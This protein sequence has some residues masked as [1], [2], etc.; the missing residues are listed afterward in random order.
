[1]SQ[2]DPRPW[3]TLYRPGLDESTVTRRSTLVD[4][5][6]DR[7][8]S[9]P[10]RVAIAYFDAMLSARD[11]DSMSDALAA[12]LQDRGVGSGDRVGIHL[13][14]IPQYALAM[15]ALW[16][17][18]AAAVVL[19]PM[20]FG[21]ELRLPVEDSGAVGI[22]A[23]DRDVPAIRD[24]VSGTAVAWVLSTSERDL[25]TRND[26]R[27]FGDDHSVAPSSDGD[28][29]VLMGEYQGRT[30]QRAEVTPDDLAL[31]T[32]TSGT[33]GPPKGAMNSHANVIAVARSFA[34][35]VG[36]VPGDVVLAIA[37]LFHITGAVINATLGLIE[38][39]TLVFAGRFR[40]EVV[41]DA[42][43]EHGVTFTI[44]SITAYNALMRLDE[45]RPEH[46]A[47]VKALY[48]GGA[49]IPPSTV[50]R[51]AERFGHY[52]HNGYGMTETTSG[53]IA[54]PP[55]QRAPVDTASGTL[56]IGVPLPGVEAAVVGVDDQPVGAGEQGEL[57]LS[58]PQI[59]SGYWRNEAATA[60]TMPGGR[61]HTGDVAVMDADG[62]VYLVDR[63]KDQ[64]NTSGYK[65]WPRE[66]EDALYEHDA[67]FE[68][69]VVGLPDEY[70]GEKV[71]AF[72]S[73]K[74]GRTVSEDDLVAFAAGRLAAYKRPNEVHLVTELPKT[75]TGKIRRRELRDEHS[76][77]TDH[78]TEGP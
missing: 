70:R 48:S 13:Q 63:L 25:Q 8:A 42:F 66:V 57:V 30:P 23:T 55:G 62:W 61:L 49:P 60:S 41:L 64:I 5:W 43:R 68:V 54:V 46:F 9:S 53:V 40:P 2:D 11:V 39:T 76:P 26:P 3:R 50:E 67:V 21:R 45:A 1:M 47:A 16:K 19:N 59:V 29:V 14:N 65:V 20:Y 58:G 32:Y 12:A 77:S 15:L 6:R 18:G 73:L 36:I 38:H 56:S 34:D 27:A 35:F 44:G 10:D 4:A 33:T 74:D 37:P 28:L 24:A 31:L 22:I 7:V 78:P 52:I 72:V 69:A 51:F 17:I 71:A 75:Q